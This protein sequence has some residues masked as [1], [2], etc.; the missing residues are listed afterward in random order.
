[1]NSVLNSVLGSAL[2]WTGLDGW[3][4]RGGMCLSVGRN[5]PNYPLLVN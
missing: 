4:R 2:D 5:S 1:M 3:I